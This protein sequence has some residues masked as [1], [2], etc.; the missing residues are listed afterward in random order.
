MMM[1]ENCK[2]G[3]PISEKDRRQKFP[4]FGLIWGGFDHP[5][6]NWFLQC[7][8]VSSM[9]LFLMYNSQEDWKNEAG[10]VNITTQLC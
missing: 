9:F 8:N 10:Q 6:I 4:L 2:D 7:F 5:L 1:D 3:F